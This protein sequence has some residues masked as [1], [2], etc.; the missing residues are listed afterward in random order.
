MIEFNNTDKDVNNVCVRL[1]RINI[2]N[3][4]NIEC[5]EIDFSNA[6][7]KKFKASILGL[8]GQNGSGKTTLIDAIQLLQFS[9]CGQ[10]IPAQFAD[11][12]NI[13][14]KSA[15]FLF[16]FEI[17][18]NDNKKIFSYECSIKKDK[19]PSALLRIN[20]LER[21]PF[22]VTVFNEILYNISENKPIFDTR[23]NNYIYMF[24]ANEKLLID[25]DVSQQ[26]ASNLSTSFIFSENFENI[27]RKSA[28]TNSVLK[29][30]ANI[31]NTL[32]YYAKY[33]LFVINSSQI[34]IITPLFL[35]FK[36]DNLSATALK[37]LPV[38]FDK[39]LAS[40][41]REK[42]QSIRRAINSMNIVL[43]QIVHGLKI[44]IK[45]LGSYITKDRKDSVEIQFMS[46]R[47]GQEIPFQYE[48]KGLKKIVSILH[49]LIAV[50]NQESITVAIDE[51]D[52]G[53][54]E[55]LLGELLKII[56]EQGRGQLIFTS[57]NLRPLET[58]DKNFVAFTTANS[59][60]CYTR[61]YNAKENENL[62]GLYFRNIILGGQ[63]E[64]L[65]NSTNKAEISLA[66]REAWNYG[67]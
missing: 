32:I 60:K 40:F 18:R 31:L 66:F 36:G 1:L 63:P 42:L 6:S 13:G 43:S 7:T 49:L 55:Y 20:E 17:K 44:S 29:E 48:S 19:T 53:V 57:H 34:E 9:M 11:Y 12:I 37:V 21:N 8:Y 50:Y 5:G 62:R 46:N 24:D 14:K 22:K 27:L 38:I 41:P 56:S 4:K 16:E 23:E 10:A 28:E 54:F 15:C 51:L 67:K 3:F 52:S 65:Y 25:L 30:C 59:A 64:I 39:P 2:K 26:L 35:A 33:E 58:L 61:I 47:N 45:E